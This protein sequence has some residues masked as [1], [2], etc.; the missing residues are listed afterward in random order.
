M[1]QRWVTPSHLVRSAVWLNLLMGAVNL[2]PAW[3]LD[4]S[5]AAEEKTDSED[6]EAAEL[7]VQGLLPN[8][9]VALGRRLIGL[10]FAVALVVFGI[11]SMNWWILAGGMTVLMFAQAQ[12]QGLFPGRAMQGLTV[13]EVMLTDFAV[14]SASA[15]LE[16]ALLQARHSQQDIYPVVRGGAVVG[17]I[18]RQ[19]ALDAL[20]ARGNSYVQGAMMRQFQTVTA[21]EPLGKAWA[22]VTRSAGAQVSSLVP[23]LDG[24]RIVGL[25]TP[26]H[27]HRA[28][29]LV[30]RERARK[31]A[32][33]LT[34]E[35]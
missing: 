9:S 35:R 5:R 33:Q 26:E 17:A 29:A 24:D 15:T 16:D 20:E 1:G 7:N 19:A 28:M 27:L 18:G 2:L 31:T 13:G 21:S 14:L 6:G 8:G 25:L 10:S 34:E 12:R 22:R 32:A 23:V 3:P 11:I 30:N 4:G